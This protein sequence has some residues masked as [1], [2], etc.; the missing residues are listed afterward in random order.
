MDDRLLIL[1]LSLRTVIGVHPHERKGPQELLLGLEIECD[2]GPASRSDALEDTLDYDALCGEITALAEKSRF[3]LIERMAGAVA[4]LVLRFEG[5][6][7]AVTVTVDKPGALDAARSAA[8][9][10]RRERGGS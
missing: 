10:I 6:V 1:D 5:R 4:D 7:Q 3:Q 8:V 2:L 9:R